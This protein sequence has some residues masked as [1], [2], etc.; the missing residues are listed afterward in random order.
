MEAIRSGSWLSRERVTRIATIS[1]V[2][3]AAMLLGFWFTRTGTVDHFGQP[4]G[5][6]F[7]AFWHA[8]RLALG[9]HAA[10]A[11]DLD[12]LNAQVTATHGV[13]YEIAWLYP[14]VFLLVAAAL[15]T[16]PYLAALLFWQL[17]SLGLVAFT[18]HRILKDG[19]ATLIALAGP[20][21]FMVLAHGQNSFLTAALLGMGLLLSERRPFLAGALLGGLVYKPQLALVIGPVLLLTRNWRALVAAALSAGALVGLSTIIWG[22]DAWNAFSASLGEARGYMEQGAV[23]FHKS[24]SLF[25]MVRLWD[26]SIGLGYAVQMLGLLAALLMIWR[27]RS[28]PLNVRAVSVCAAAALSTPYLIDYDMAVAGIGAAFLYAEARETGFL[29][30]ERSALAFIWAAPWISRPAAEF[31]GIPL[32]PMAMLMLAWC[33]WRR[34]SGHRHAAVDVDSLPRD[35]TGL[36]AR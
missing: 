5:S 29:P 22:V 7:T 8:G 25:S 17:F 11:W 6:D 9:G 28:A 32:G 1:G 33:A 34:A 35:V 24:A 2:I 31:A 14:P 30:Y 18:L 36:A 3:G 20:L 10:S 4:V 21:T 12:M 15:A 27:S 16:M 13:S 26:G 19:R 23:G